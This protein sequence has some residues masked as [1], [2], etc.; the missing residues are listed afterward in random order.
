MKQHIYTT[1]KRTAAN[2]WKTSPRYATL[3]RIDPTLP[4]IKFLK[5]TESLSK[6]QVSLLV[7]LRTSYIDLNAHLHRIGKTVSPKCEACGFHKETVYRYLLEC[8]AHA[9]ART[10][11]RRKLPPRSLNMATLLGNAAYS[12]DVFQFVH[13]TGQLSTTFPNITR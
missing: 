7:Q 9:Q 8:P 3:N 2:H 13:A 5:S 11:L 10:P 6:Q 4:S 1:L 12:K